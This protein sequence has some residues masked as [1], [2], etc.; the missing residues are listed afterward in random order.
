MNSKCVSNFRFRMHKHFPDVRATLN[1]WITLILSIMQIKYT[2]VR[3]I[4]QKSLMLF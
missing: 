3:I 2:E 1:T 4:V